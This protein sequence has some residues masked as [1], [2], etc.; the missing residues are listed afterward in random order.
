MKKKWGCILD[1]RQNRQHIVQI[2]GEIFN[3]IILGIITVNQSY[4]S[5]DRYTAASNIPKMFSSLIALFI[6]AFAFVSLWVYRE[7]DYEKENK[8]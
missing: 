3:L 5:F 1:N 8:N 4:G 7:S 2:Y 6:A